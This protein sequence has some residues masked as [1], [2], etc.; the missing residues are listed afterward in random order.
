MDAYN[1][2]WMSLPWFCWNFATKDNN[3]SYTYNSLYYSFEKPGFYIQYRRYRSTI[4]LFILSLFLSEFQCIPSRYHGQN[5]TKPWRYRDFRF[6]RLTSAWPGRG[7]WR[8]SLPHTSCLLCVLDSF[9]VLSIAT[10]RVFP[11][12]SEKT[13][14]MY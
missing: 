9:L 6:V 3:S 12:G 4:P 11:A 5:L 14:R 13:P 1:W 2:F 7:F 8:Y 10:F